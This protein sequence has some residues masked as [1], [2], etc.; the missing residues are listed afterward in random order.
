MGNSKAAQTEATRRKL[1]R[2]GRELFAKRGFAQVSSEELVARAGVTRGALYHHYD[3]KEGLFEV[4]VE[5]VMRDL[6]SSLVKD[7]SR[8][9]DPLGALEHSIDT[10]LKLCAEPATQRILLVD[11]PT[12]LG[13]SRWREM[14]AKYGLGLLKRGLSAAMNAG[15]LRRQ[16]V[17]M[18]AHLLLGALTE[19]AMVVAR[20]P[21]P[22]A[23]RQAAVQAL[24]SMLDSQKPQG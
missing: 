13:W 20:S 1:E 8:F 17:D 6:H 5:A 2:V 14:D 21:K 23:A 24:R 4:V 12:V 3:G 18:L 7:A 11:G 16:D 10:F 19:A 22:T 15:Q 9:A